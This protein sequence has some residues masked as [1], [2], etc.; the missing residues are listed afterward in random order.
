MSIYTFTN[1]KH[2]KL[3]YC[4]HYYSNQR[5]R[6]MNSFNTFV[7]IS[8]EIASQTLLTRAALRKCKLLQRK[9]CANDNTSNK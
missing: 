2:T 9:F 8:A 4:N 7:G 6:K 5:L 1:I 3:T